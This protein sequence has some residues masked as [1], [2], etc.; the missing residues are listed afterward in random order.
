MSSRARRAL[1]SGGG[2]GAGLKPIVKESQ[3]QQML[4]T[5]IQAGR[6]PQENGQRLYFVYLPPNVVSYYDQVSHN[7]RGHHA[8]FQTT[9]WVPNPNPNGIGGIFKT[10]VTETVYYAVIVNPI[11]IGDFGSLND[12]QSLTKTSSHELAE[13]V[14]NPDFRVNDFGPISGGHQA[15]KD[16]HG[17]EIG[18]IVHTYFIDF[19]AGGSTYL[20]QL[21]WSNH[22]QKGIVPDGSQAYQLDHLPLNTHTPVF[23]AYSF[24]NGGRTATV[25][26]SLGQNGRWYYDYL[27]PDGS[28]GGWFTSLPS[29]LFGF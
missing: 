6:L 13:A 20:V 18:D 24:D 16:S 28:H 17:D 21:E 22:F 26:V 3:I 25:E 29:G 19:V 9:I 14:T 23:F 27:L 8:S 4:T 12:W 1:P 7:L 11:T 15:W 2:A 10:P 5:E